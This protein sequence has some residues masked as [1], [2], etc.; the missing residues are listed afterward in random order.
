MLFFFNFGS[1]NE[2]LHFLVVNCDCYSIITREL[3]NC[4]VESKPSSYQYYPHFANYLICKADFNRISGPFLRCGCSLI[5]PFL[6]IRLFPV[7]INGSNLHMLSFLVSGSHGGVLFEVEFLLLICVLSS[8]MI[9][10]CLTLV[11]I[12]ITYFK[13]RLATWNSRGSS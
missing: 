9:V 3:I 11:I 7:T 1:L 13:L 5:M 8:V 12:S 6:S 2:L 4:I 10:P